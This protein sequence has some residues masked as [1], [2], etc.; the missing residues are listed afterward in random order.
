MAASRRG[1]AEGQAVSDPFNFRLGRTWLIVWGTLH[2]RF[3][4][5]ILQ[6][7]PTH[8]VP[9]QR[10]H[11]PFLTSTSWRASA[12]SISTILRA[13]PLCGRCATP[14]TSSCVRQSRSPG[15]EC[16]RTCKKNTAHSAKASPAAKASWG[17]GSV[18]RFSKVS[19][20]SPASF[21]PTCLCDGRSCHA[22]P[23]SL[24]NVCGLERIIKSWLTEASLIGLTTTGCDNCAIRSVR[25]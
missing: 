24:S 1:S 20:G 4:F 6:C 13:A 7:F 10:L 17:W 15:G 25:H 9:P 3:R 8:P 16:D 12:E 11:L 19:L 5:W 22:N 2:P 23:V 18:I 21:S 14:N